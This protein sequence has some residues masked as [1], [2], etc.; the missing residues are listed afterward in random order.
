MS[1]DTTAENSAGPSSGHL[2][3]PRSCPLA[4]ALLGDKPRDTEDTRNPDNQTLMQELK[5]EFQ[6]LD[7]SGQ[8]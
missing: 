7:F 2:V 8:Q 6:G 5:T 4:P 1:H 3:Y